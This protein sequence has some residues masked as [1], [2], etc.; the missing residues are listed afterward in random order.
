MMKST[1]LLVLALFSAHGVIAGERAQ[2]RRVMIHADGEGLDTCALAEVK[3]LD[4]RG[5]NFLAVRAGPGTAYAMRDRLH[6][7]DRVWL[8]DQVGDWMGIVYG[9]TEIECGP[10]TRDRPYDGPGRTGWVY[11]RYLKPLAG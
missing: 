11:K 5:D 9:S 1:L 2:A 7:G 3:G 10:E 6:T 4:P 8:F